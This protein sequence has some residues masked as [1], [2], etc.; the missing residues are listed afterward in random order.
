[1]SGIKLCIVGKWKGWKEGALFTE[2]GSRSY[3]CFVI[4]MGFILLCVLCN[5]CWGLNTHI[6]YMCVTVSS[7]DICDLYIQ[8]YIVNITCVCAGMH[9]THTY[10]L[11]FFIS[12]LKV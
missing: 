3:L 2:E 6:Q 1:M 4:Q 8:L 12:Q 10:V 11:P 9:A 5:L 7:S